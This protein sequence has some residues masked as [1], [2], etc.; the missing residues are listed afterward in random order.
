M[1]VL[2]EMKVNDVKSTSQNATSLKCLFQRKRFIFI[3]ILLELHKKENTSVDLLAYFGIPY[4]V[5]IN[6]LIYF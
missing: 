6:V 1:A 3:Y 5:L 4:S 2:H